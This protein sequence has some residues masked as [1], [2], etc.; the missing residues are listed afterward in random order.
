MK[1]KLRVTPQKLLPLAI[2]MAF[3]LSAE[4]RDMGVGL[5]VSYI[6]GKGPA[7][8]IKA[9]SDDQENKGAATLGVDYVFSSQSFRPNIG[10]AYQGQ[11]YFGDVNIGYSFGEQKVDFGTGAGWSNADDR[12]KKSPPPVVISNPT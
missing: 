11:G 5:G 4:A 7:V 9:F 2:L 12:H 3:S 6:F 8:G 1:E 10:V